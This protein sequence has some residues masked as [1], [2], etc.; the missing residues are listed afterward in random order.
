MVKIDMQILEINRDDIKKL[1][2]D[3]ADS[4]VVTDNANK[5]DE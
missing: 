2:F 3:H 5:G 4:T 1:G